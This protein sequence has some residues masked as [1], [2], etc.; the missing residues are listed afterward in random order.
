M[1]KK[2]FHTNF[3]SFHLLYTTVKLICQIK[4]KIINTHFTALILSVKEKFT[5]PT[6]LEIL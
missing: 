2:Y 1:M 3:H 6:R 4:Y 5:Q